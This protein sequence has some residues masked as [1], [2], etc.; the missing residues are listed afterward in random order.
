MLFLYGLTNPLP[1]RQLLQVWGMFSNSEAGTV[2]QFG[3]E[4]DIP[5]LLDNV[6]G[7]I[8]QEA[9]ANPNEPV[10]IAG[11][12]VGE[13]VWSDLVNLAV[14][15]GRRPPPDLCIPLNRR[16]SNSDAFFSVNKIYSQG[17][18]REE[19]PMA[20]CLN[21]WFPDLDPLKDESEIIEEY[22]ANG[23]LSDESAV[24]CADYVRRMKAVT[25][26]YYGRS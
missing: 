6:H 15:E 18:Y 19:P 12:K 22:E 8:V 14:R 1:T 9:A 25:D 23:F 16:Y 24:T 5:K 4:Q 20:A 13:C 21:F 10:K 7:A 2:Y 17:F 3:G 26:I 11:W